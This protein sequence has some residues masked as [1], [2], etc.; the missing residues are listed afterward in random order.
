MMM[1]EIGNTVS[2]KGGIGIADSLY[3]EMIKQQEVA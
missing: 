3:R 2:R 1:D